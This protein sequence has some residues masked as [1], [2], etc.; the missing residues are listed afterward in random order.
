MDLPSQLSSGASSAFVIP[1]GSIAAMVRAL[2][3]GGQASGS[4][5]DTACQTLRLSHARGVAECEALGRFF[6][7][8]STET[9][10]RVLVLDLLAQA[11]TPQ[12][13]AVMRRLLSL[14]VAR[15]DRRCFASFIQRVGYV[16]RPEVDTLRFLVSVYAETRHEAEV[17]TACAYAV[18]AVAG[19]AHVWGLVEPAMRACEALRRDLFSASEREEKCL[20]LAALGHAGLDAD[21]ATILRFVDERERRV[22]SAAVLALRKMHTPEAKAWLLSTLGKAHPTLAEDALSALFEQLFSPEELVRLAELVLANRTPPALDRRVLRLI[23]TQKPGAM[24]M[25]DGPVIDAAVKL[26][27]ERLDA[28]RNTE[29]GPPPPP[30]PPRP[31]PR[32][33]L[34]G[35]SGEYARYSPA[36]DDAP[37]TLASVAPPLK[38]PSY[39]PPLRRS[40]PPKMRSSAS[41]ALRACDL[42]EAPV[43]V[44]IPPASAVPAPSPEQPSEIRFSAS[45]SPSSTVTEAQTR[46]AFHVAVPVVPIAI[47]R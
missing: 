7:D 4:L 17:H 27:L 30:A 9:D 42:S 29:G 2:P 34:S 36:E 13:Q 21:V 26:L 3:K 37:I 14:D 10:R 6:E 8:E 18:G 31:A 15:R 44:S 20:L 41:Q 47:V 33:R 23:V 25:V 24:A 38:P 19:R 45:P 16:E 46:S 1:P 32:L 22:R 35:E 40:T 39:A 43:P 12:A 28:P 5:R 11:G